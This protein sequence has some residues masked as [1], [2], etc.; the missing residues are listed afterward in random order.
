MPYKNAILGCSS[1]CTELF[2][3]GQLTQQLRNT[4]HFALQT[5]PAKKNKTMV[6]ETSYC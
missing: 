3:G 1:W 4:E 6:L 2:I 5:K